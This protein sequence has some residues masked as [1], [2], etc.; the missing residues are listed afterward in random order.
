MPDRVSHDHPTVETLTATL[1]RY[2]GTTRPEVRLP[3]DADLPVGDVVRLILDGTEYR[4]ELL[5]RADGTPVIRG[6]FE[7]PRLARDPGSATDHLR[8]WVDDRDLATGRTV[9]VDVVEPGQ[10]YGLRAPGES[11]TYRSTG[12][13]KDSLAAIAEDLE[14]R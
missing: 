9:Y 14:D 4:A 12:S 6:A 10:T 13:P 2:G 7:T 1:G 3:G 11:S 5:D 8:A